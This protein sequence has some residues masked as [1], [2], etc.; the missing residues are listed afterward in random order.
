MQSDTATEPDAHLDAEAQPLNEL[1]AGLPAAARGDNVDA[2]EADGVLVDEDLGFGRI[3]ASEIE[4]P[5]TLVNLVKWMS[6]VQSD[7][8]TEPDEDLAVLGAL[9]LGDLPGSETAVLGC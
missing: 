7:N 4:A 3:D 5:N 9:V 8:A 2:V 1:D 6:I